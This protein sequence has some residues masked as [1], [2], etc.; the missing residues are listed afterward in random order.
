MFGV[1]SYLEAHAYSLK[2]IYQIKQMH[3]RNI[4]DALFTTLSAIR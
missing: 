3:L 2:R 1:F 4:V